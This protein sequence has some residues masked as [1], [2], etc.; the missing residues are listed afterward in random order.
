MRVG[1][2]TDRIAKFVSRLLFDQA[3]TIIHAAFGY[4]HLLTL[5][6]LL[7]ILED[8]SPIIKAALGDHLEDRA[9]FYTN[10]QAIEERA[11]RIHEDIELPGDDFT[12]DDLRF[13]DEELEL[14]EE[15]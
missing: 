5:E 1:D 12:D 8:V 11:N 7:R 10:Q 2:I 14:E 6:S 4:R 9:R 3:V 15:D 13:T